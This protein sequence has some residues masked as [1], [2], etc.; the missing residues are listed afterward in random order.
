MTGSEPVQVSR[1]SSPHLVTIA[2]TDNSTSGV[3][4]TT[5]Q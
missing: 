4:A 2:T 3:E 5:I 1:L